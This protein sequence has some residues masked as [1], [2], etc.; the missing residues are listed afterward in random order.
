MFAT[1]RCSLHV[2]YGIATHDTR[3]KKRGKKR[4]EGGTTTALAQR[5]HTPFGSALRAQQNQRSPW[6]WLQPTRLLCATCTKNGDFNPHLLRTIKRTA[7]AHTLGS[8]K[9]VRCDFKLGWLVNLAQVAKQNHVRWSYHGPMQCV[10]DLW[11]FSS[12]S[13]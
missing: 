13:G 6:F 5:G 10:P 1:L 9:K 2:L 11:L 8:E 12:K 7:V 3:K 4:R